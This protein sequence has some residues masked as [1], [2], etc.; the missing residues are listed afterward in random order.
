MYLSDWRIIMKTT[1]NLKQN[2]LAY[3]LLNHIKAGLIMCGQNE[4]GEIEW[5]GDKQKWNLLEELN[6]EYE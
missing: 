5:L 3:D 4:Y 6:K 1:T 2:I